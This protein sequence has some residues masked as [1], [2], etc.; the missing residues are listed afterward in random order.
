MLG[1]LQKKSAVIVGAGRLGCALLEYDG[2][3]IYGLEI[4]AAFDINVGEAKTT[5]SGK[6]LLPIENLEEYCKANGV[7]IGIIT[8]PA[9][10]AQEVCD[11]LV[12][13]GVKGVWNFAPKVL[14]VPRGITLRQEN[15]ALSLAHLSIKLDSNK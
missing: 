10:E 4:T 14:S 15:L 5:E 7:L 2:F 3:D 1:P 6:K 11:R 8:V 9:E 12:K 13:C